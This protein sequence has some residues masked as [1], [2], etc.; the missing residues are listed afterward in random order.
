MIEL[1]ARR[2]RMLGEPQRLRILQALECGEKTVNEVVEAVQGNQSNISRHLQALHEAGL[3][4]RRREGNHVC[5]GIADPVVLQLC[6]IVCRST[7]EQ[8]QQ[9]FETA[10]GTA[11]RKRR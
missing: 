1:V 5:Y 8:L 9:E 3:V 7:S 11:P 2:F 6:E 4:S 10:T